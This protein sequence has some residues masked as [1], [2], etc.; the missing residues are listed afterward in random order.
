VCDDCGTQ[1]FCIS[2]LE[3]AEGDEMHIARVGGHLKRMDR[4]AAGGPKVPRRGP[5]A[6]ARDAAPDLLSALLQSYQ[7]LLRLMVRILCTD[8]G[9]PAAL[10]GSVKAV[11]HRYLHDWCACPV[12]GCECEGLCACADECVCVC[13]CDVCVCVWAHVLGRCTHVSCAWWW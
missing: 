10:E 3:E 6:G 11:W 9:C 13:V 7:A 12:G 5:G 4:R 2:Q 1:L 8:L